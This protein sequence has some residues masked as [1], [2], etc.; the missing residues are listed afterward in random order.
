MSYY[1]EINVEYD[2]GLTFKPDMYQDAVDYLK[3]H[4]KLVNND[5]VRLKSSA[6]ID[7]DVMD[8]ILSFEYMV[9]C[10]ALEWNRAE[11]VTFGYLRSIGKTDISECVYYIC[12]QFY[13]G[14]NDHYIGNNKIYEFDD[15]NDFEIS[16]E[17]HEEVVISSVEFFIN[18]HTGSET[19]QCLIKKWDISKK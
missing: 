17:D 18:G 5:C 4:V 2:I 16:L 19:K 11:L 14:N 3:E 9:K 1:R 13:M 12:L 7:G 8:K 15:I 6:D 10:F